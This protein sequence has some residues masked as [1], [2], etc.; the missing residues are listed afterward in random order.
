M[1]LTITGKNQKKAPEIVSGAYS[2]NG[3]SLT[4]LPIGFV[5]SYLIIADG[6]G[7]TWR[8]GYGLGWY[9]QLVG[10]TGTVS[11]AHC[12]FQYL[13]KSLDD[14]PDESGND[15]AEAYITDD[16]EAG[17]IITVEG[18]NVSGTTYVFWAIS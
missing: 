17:V 16:D 1:A 12:I 4:T 5:P 11:N 3:A 7:N 9:T 18:P 10:S 2:G 15:Y 13:G 8:W 14:N 6:S